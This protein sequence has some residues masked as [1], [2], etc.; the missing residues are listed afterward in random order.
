[1]VLMMTGPPSTILIT[2]N[3]RKQIKIESSPSMRR[4]SIINIRHVMLE[5]LH[6]EA[7]VSTVQPWYDSFQ[8]SQ[9]GG[10]TP[11]VVHALVLRKPIEWIYSRI[12]REI[13]ITDDHINQ[14]CNTDKYEVCR[15]LVGLVLGGW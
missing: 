9:G 1:M 15:R 3:E 4:A 14:I 7:P 2:A 10:R 13:T 8:K 12:I 5:P 6:L 11:C